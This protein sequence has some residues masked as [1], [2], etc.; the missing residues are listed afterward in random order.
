MHLRLVTKEKQMKMKKVIRVRKIS[1]K[2]L[3]ACEQAG[4][5]VILV[6]GVL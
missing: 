2:Q 4:I 1:D 5:R 6:G 3:Q